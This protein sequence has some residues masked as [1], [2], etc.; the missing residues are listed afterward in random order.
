MNRALLSMKPRLESMGE[1]VEELDF[2]RHCVSVC[3][4]VLQGRA[5]VIG[6][7]YLYRFA[8]GSESRGRVLVRVEGVITRLRLSLIGGG[9]VIMIS[10]RQARTKFDIQVM[11]LL[12]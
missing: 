4:G 7:R 12:Q 1:M 5:S 2:M 6:R 10:G 11:V 8:A 9:R 3:K